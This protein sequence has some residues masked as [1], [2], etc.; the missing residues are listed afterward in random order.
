MRDEV[1]ER[2]NQNFEIKKREREAKEREK[3]DGYGVWRNEVKEGEEQ[4]EK[5]LWE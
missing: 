5:N 1:R 3:R 4:S 2:E